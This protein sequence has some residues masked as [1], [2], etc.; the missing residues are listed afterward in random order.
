MSASW[1]DPPKSG[2]APRAKTLLDPDPG[3]ERC[4]R[5]GHRRFLLGA[6]TWS[7][8]LAPNG[9]PDRV[10]QRR[11][12]RAGAT[13]H[14]RRA[15]G[16]PSSAVIWR[17]ARSMSRSAVGRTR[18]SPTRPRQLPRPHTTCR[19]PSLRTPHRHK[20]NHE[21]AR[22][23]T[24]NCSRV[25]DQGGVVGE[26][27]EVTASCGRH[28]LCGT[29]PELPQ[30]GRIEPGCSRLTTPESRYSGDESRRP[31]SVVGPGSAMGLL[32]GGS[33]WWPTWAW[34]DPGELLICAAHAHRR[35]VQ[36]RSRAMNTVAFELVPPLLEAGTEK[37][38]RRGAS[39]PS[40][41]APAG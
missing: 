12:A 32:C 24:A 4:A 17:R 25:L 26:G 9:A 35:V 18:H 36:Y 7:A 5:T 33:A 8:Q 37:P 34:A 20:N 29:G 16:A 31:L 22:C 2:P 40:S 1:R 19:L 39:S 21:A 28:Y 23:S 6:S 30:S 13:R 10:N 15:V 38:S 41:S 27:L 14:D 11:R 3:T